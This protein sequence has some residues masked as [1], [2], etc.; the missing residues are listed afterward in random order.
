VSAPF[1]IK[2]TIAAGLKDERIYECLNLITAV[3]A[4]RENSKLSNQYSQSP[5]LGS[6]LTW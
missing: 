6:Q 5:E 1:D 3:S 4:K 2:A